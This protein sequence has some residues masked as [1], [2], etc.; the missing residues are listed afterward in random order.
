MVERAPSKLFGKLNNSAYLIIEV[1]SFLEL[2][3]ANYLMFSVGL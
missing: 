2:E 3:K 1:L